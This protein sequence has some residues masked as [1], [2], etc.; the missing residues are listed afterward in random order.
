MTEK[1]IFQLESVTKTFSVRQGIFSKGP[2]FCALDRIYLELRRGVFYGLVGASGSGKSTLAHLLVG[3]THPTEGKI[4][5]DGKS[6]ADNLRK[7]ERRFRKKVQMIFQNPYLSLDSK[8]S[9]E[10]IVGEGIDSLHGRRKRERVSEALESVELKKEYRT[11]RPSELSG[12]ERQRAA[13]AR[14]LAVQPE[15]L[16]LDEPTSQLDVSIQ[17]QIV[18]LLKRLRPLF[19]SGMLFISHD[20]ALVSS[21]VDEMIVL[22]KGQ[23]VEQGPGRELLANPR[24]PYT[25]RLKN[26]VPLWDP[27]HYS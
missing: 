14:A 4:L 7:E 17:A 22:Q 27:E 8:W 25:E 1:F 6:L 11:R 10:A 5:F 15:F 13:I 12:G 20:L 26:A 2:V 9:V 24:H 21:L 23:V 19:R 3:L 16:I 18:R